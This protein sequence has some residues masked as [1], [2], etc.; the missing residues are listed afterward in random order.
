MEGLNLT[1]CERAAIPE[2]GDT[3]KGAPLPGDESG[4]PRHRADFAAFC[5]R[6]YSDLLAAF[7]RPARALRQDARDVVQET[8][9]RAIEWVDKLDS[10]GAASQLSEDDMLAWCRVVGRN[11]L[12]DLANAGYTKR[13]QL[14]PSPT[15]AISDPEQQAV[16]RADLGRVLAIL[17]TRDA[18]ILFLKSQSYTLDEIAALLHLKPASVGKMLERARAAAQE[19]RWWQIVAGLFPVGVVRQSLQSARRGLTKPSQFAVATLT[20]LSVVVAFGVPVVPA[21]VAIP[22]PS[23]HG[24]AVRPTAAIRH[25]HGAPAQGG[26]SRLGPVSRAGTARPPA[27]SGEQRPTLIPRVPRAC[28]SGVCVAPSCSAQ[29]EAGD[30]LY[31]KPYGPCGF[32]VTE[33]KTPVCPYVADNPAVGCRRS[34]KPNW[35]INP[36][37]P[38]PSP[39]PNP[40]RDPL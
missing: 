9:T 5:D 14:H 36:P 38:S 12:R 15:A 21:P 39:S 19:G 37:P 4:V 2:P 23:A 30:A 25:M 3:T 27:R 22:A 40:E 10:L 31:V 28:T 29:D 7:M 8:I 35:D 18:K 11:Y 32:S 26:A 20:S 17:P 13:E 34:G 1:I 24:S 33:N 16:E 6:R